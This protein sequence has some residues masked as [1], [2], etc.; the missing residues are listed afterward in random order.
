MQ[1][2]VITASHNQPEWLKRCVRSVADQAPGVVVEHIIQQTKDPAPGI[3][4]WVQAN[5]NARVFV[6]EDEG[7]YDAWNRGL[8][9]VGGDFFAMLNCDE[10]YLPGALM[11]VEQA[12][13]ENPEADIVAGDYLITDEAGKLLS[14]RRATPLRASMILTDHLYDFTCALFFRRRVIGRGIFFDLAYGRRG[15]GGAGAPQRRA[16]GLCERIP[17]HICDHGEKSQPGSGPHGRD[18]ADAEIH[19]ALGGGGSAVAAA[20][21]AHGEAP[22]G[23][24]Q[25]QADRV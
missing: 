25:F 23:R 3:V 5:A 14:Y 12:F 13:K 19:A 17:G 9:R 21:P 22:A 4:E 1:F 8:R 10:Q 7:M 15:L 20:I 18:R 11:R 6:E 2:S 16:R 24:I